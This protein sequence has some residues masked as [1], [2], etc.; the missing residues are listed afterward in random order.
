MDHVTGR[1]IK[2]D[3]E[4]KGA[5]QYISFGLSAGICNRIKRLFSALRFNVNWEKP[6]DVYW[7][8]G[9][10]TNRPFYELFKFDLYEFNEIPCKVKINK[11]DEYDVGSDIVWRLK[12]KD[13][14]LPDG[15]TKA[16]PKDDNSKEYIDFEYERI[17]LNVLQIYMKYFN[18]LRP[19]DQV[20]SRIESVRLPENCVSVH[21]RPGRYWNE[22]GRGNRDSI[23]PYIDEMKKLPE[24]TSFF[25]AAANEVFA[26]QVR[27][28][29]PGR[30]IELPNKDFQDAIDAVAELYL[31]GKTKVLLATGASTFSEVAWWL[32]G[33]KQEVKVIGDARKWSVKCPICGGDSEIKRSYTRQDCLAEYRHL[34]QDV[35]DDL[36]TVDYE[37]RK[38]NTCG[39]VFANPMRPG[40]QNFYTWVTGHGN[41]YPTVRTPRWEWGE[42]RTYVKENHVQKL[43]EVG[44]GTGEFLD[45][46]RQ[47]VTIEAVGLDTTVSSYEKCIQKGLKAYNVPLEKYILDHEV[48]YDVVVA[49]HLLEHV[50]NPL[51]LVKGMMK[52]L[53]PGG[54]C[55]L[56]FPY[57]DSRIEKCITTANN[58]PPHHLTCWEFPAIQALATAVNANLEVV[59]P[60]SSTVK[61]EVQ[62]RLRNEYFPLYEI[63]SK[64]KMYLAAL[65]NFRRTRE[66]I[67]LKKTLKDINIADHIGAES[68]VRRPPWF[69]LIVLS[70]RG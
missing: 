7:S 13:G 15:F 55:M 60:E 23:A 17:P 18:A 9:E 33:G 41:Y 6:L 3:A 4:K 25:L 63:V 57:T 69:V 20:Q 70:K 37:M 14:E 40:S 31:L 51:E 49:F 46:L 58:M 28:E 30:I 11:E 34:Y 53:T 35:P 32:G 66:I 50:E 29:F 16:Y 5:K 59:G 54:K 39:L 22:Y 61:A 68:V 62:S 44:C 36:E 48:Q 52:L 2:S 26:E 8:L 43:L 67:E 47:E 56:S 19:S 10:L 42:I 1:D 24:D 12:V 38:C 65:R 27:R 45:Y 21:L 64:Y